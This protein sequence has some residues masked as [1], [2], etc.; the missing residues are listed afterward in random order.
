MAFLRAFEAA[1]FLCL[2]KD[3][4]KKKLKMRQKSM[5]KRGLGKS[6]FLKDIQFREE[7]V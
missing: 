2:E 4:K 6:S 5:K 1:L 7:L 3:C